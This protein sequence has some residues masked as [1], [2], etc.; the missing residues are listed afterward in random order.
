MNGFTYDLS[1]APFVTKG[2]SRSITAENPTG[3]KGE[4][5][6]DYSNLGQGRKGRPCIRLK[7]G[8]TVTLAQIDGTGVLQ[9]FWITVTDKTQE[10]G[11]A[12]SFVLRDLILRIYW[13][14]E[15]EPSVEVPLGDFFCNG[16]ATRT[17]V[18]SMPISVNPTGGMN[19]YFPMPFRK[20]ATITIENQHAYD[21]GAFFYTFNYTLMDELPENTAYFHAQ[22]RRE[23][24]TEI[25]KDYT[26][27][28]NVKGTGQY[29]GTYLAWA[30]LERNWWGEGE[31][32]F[33]MDGDDEWPTICGTGT[34]DY[35]GGA[36][37]FAGEDG[38]ES[39]ST[40][41]LGYKFYKETAKIDPW[42]GHNVPMHGMYRWHLPDPIRFESDLKVTVQQIGHDHQG[43]FERSD[44]ISSVAYWYQME[45]HA[46]FPAML[47]KEKRWPR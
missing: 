10:K 16:F 18:N 6:K 17:I 45:P 3:A 1:T 32:K 11:F 33:Y 35:V 28:D 34:E 44:D 27:L 8:E 23:H 24:V 26:I 15:A 9:H 36:W 37:C 20:S 4:G 40:P 38:P 29:I 31:L 2:K 12:A 13:D 43:L 22:W 19:C 21:I 42:Y 14:G 46:P 47:P 7:A 41:F 39:Y 5:G 30:A 25:A